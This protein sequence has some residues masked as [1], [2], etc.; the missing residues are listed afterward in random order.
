MRLSHFQNKS[1][2]PQ[3]FARKFSPREPK[4]PNGVMG[5]WSGIGM[6]CSFSER[7]IHILKSLLN[8]SENSPN[9][10]YITIMPFCSSIKD[11]HSQ[12]SFNDNTIKGLGLKILA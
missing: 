4:C 10:G 9:L 7:I 12:A 6:A 5:W 11:C 3:L 2:I 1:Y 8:Y